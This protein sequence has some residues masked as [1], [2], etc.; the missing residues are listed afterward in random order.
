METLPVIVYAESTPNPSTLKFVINR[1]LLPDYSVTYTDASQTSK[2]PLAAELFLLNYVKA[3]YIANNFITVTKQP[4]VEWVEVMNELR[5]FIKTWFTDEKPVFTDLPPKPAVN[6]AT[7]NG[8]SLSDDA[9]EQKIIEILDEYIKPAVEQDGGEIAFKSFV[10]G[11]VSLE[12]KGSCSGCP[13]STITLKA[14]IEQ[15]LKR[16]VPGVEKVV[17]ENA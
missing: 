7:V 1:T 12:L 3:V 6:E 4:T 8:E 11:V 14:G 13:S 5:E 17:A 2:C 9:A 15:L 16:M 10:N